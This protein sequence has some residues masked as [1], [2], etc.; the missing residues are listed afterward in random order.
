MAARGPTVALDPP[1]PR[2]IQDRGGEQRLPLLESVALLGQLPRLFRNHRKRFSVRPVCDP[3]VDRALE[4]TAI[5]ERQWAGGFASTTASVRPRGAERAC[6][7]A[8]P[9]G[10]NVRDMTTCPPD[11][12][13]SAR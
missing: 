9:G 13:I 1:A 6:V 4:G 12:R 5:G 10:K 3:R 2:W 7:A 11:D 8:E